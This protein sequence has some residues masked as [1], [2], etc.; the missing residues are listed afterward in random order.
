MAH[1]TSAT[2]FTGLGGPRRSEPLALAFGVEL[3][4]IPE[5][6]EADTQVGFR[7]TKFEDLNKSPIFGRA[8]LRI[9]L[10]AGL[11]LDLG[12]TPPLTIDGVTADGIY[13]LALE[14]PVLEIGPWRAGLRAF[15]Q[16]G[17]VEGDITCSSDTVAIGVDDP[18][19]NP[20]RCARPSNDDAEL[21]YY[22]L[23]LSGS[24]RVADRRWSAFAAFA[25]TRVNAEVQVNAPLEGVLDRSRLV[26]A[27]TIRTATLGALFRPD[28]RWELGLALSYTPLDVQR[29]PDFRTR[30]DDFWS[31]RLSA[32]LAWDGLR[33]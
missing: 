24:R 2:L 6:D 23:E 12:Y 1:A 7:G 26:T 9:G 32:S 21:D 25:V 31:L 13:A 8:R 27:G 20:F 10:P 28:E 16:A 33:R 15:G 14:R 18:E 19:R 29:P 22:G 17:H 3:A 30:S 11:T 4:S 5:I